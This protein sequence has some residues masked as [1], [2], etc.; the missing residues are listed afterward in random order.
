MS[1]EDSGKHDFLEDYT[2]QSTIDAVIAEETAMVI[3]ATTIGFT[4]AVCTSIE[5]KFKNAELINSMEELGGGGM[6]EFYYVLAAY[7][8]MSCQLCHVLWSAY[9]GAFSGLYAYEVDEVF[10]AE[11]AKLMSTKGT[12][13]E[14]EI[15]LLLGKITY[16]FFDT[17]GVTT[18]IA[19]TIYK[20][21]KYR[22]ENT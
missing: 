3:V 20:H 11:L 5:G 14:A 8:K 17:N 16:D 12:V 2:P 21:T 13:G 22:K 19:D 10:G 7:A 4:E 9:P 1:T 18:D 15:K 6:L